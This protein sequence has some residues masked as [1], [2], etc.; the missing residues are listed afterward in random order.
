[1]AASAPVSREHHRRQLVPGQ[2][3]I[4]NGTSRAGT[5]PEPLVLESKG[6]RPADYEQ[7][8]ALETPCPPKR[9]NSKSG[10][11]R[12]VCPFGAGPR[13]ADRQI[14]RGSHLLAVA[15]LVQPGVAERLHAVV[16]A[17]ARAFIE[18]ARP[19]VA[20]QNPECQVAPP[21]RGE[22]FFCIAK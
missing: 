8:A 10:S 9:G 3:S 21:R 14:W 20:F 11:R 15:H 13:D 12:S 17:P 6:S 19:I 5:A 2:G 7:H 4:A 1:M 22:R 18:P 16:A